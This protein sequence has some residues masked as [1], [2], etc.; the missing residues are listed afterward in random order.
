MSN[1]QEISILLLEKVGYAVQI[2][3]RNV[4]AS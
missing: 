3:V 2:G 4:S 1:L